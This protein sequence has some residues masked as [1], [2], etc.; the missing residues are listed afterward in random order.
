MKNIAK[1]NLMIAL[2][3]IIKGSAYILMG[4]GGVANAVGYPEVGGLFLGVAALF[5]LKDTV[6]TTSTNQ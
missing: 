1:M 3:A 4:V 2:P 6:S 5:G